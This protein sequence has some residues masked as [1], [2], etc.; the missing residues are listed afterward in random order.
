VLI[1][2]MLQ[3]QGVASAATLPATLV[4]EFARYDWPGNVRQL[5]H[6]LRRASLMLAHDVTPRFEQLVRAG[7]VGSSV[8]RPMVADPAPE[9]QVSG[10]AAPGL[11]A[12]GVPAPGAPAPRRKRALPS[13]DEVLEAMARS[14]WT[15]QAAAEE[16]GISR[17]TLYKLLDEHSRIRRAERIPVEEIERALAASKGDVARCAAL[18]R[19]PAEALRRHVRRLRE[20]T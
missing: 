2:H 18:L 20:T 16:L 12:A 1:L 3:D 17:P 11:A 10:V 6:A 5:A 14:D 15:I 8:A 13:E 7:P 4:A 9:A 19:T